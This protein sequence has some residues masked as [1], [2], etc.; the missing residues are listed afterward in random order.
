MLIDE[1]KKFRETI[2]Q[3]KEIKDS[4]AKV[5]TIMSLGVN[6]SIIKSDIDELLTIMM[7]EESMWVRNTIYAVLI[8]KFGKENII[9]IIELKIK[10]LEN[11]IHQAR[12]VQL[13]VLYDVFSNDLIQPLIDG[14]NKTKNKNELFDFSEALIKLEGNKSEGVKIIQ[15]LNITGELDFFQKMRY[16]TL[17]SNFKINESVEVMNQMIELEKEIESLKKQLAEKERKDQPLNLQ[18]KM[19]KSLLETQSGNKNDK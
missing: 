14:L 8:Q 11:N 6:E 5:V 18:E 15:R 17:I 9:T 16:K 2:A 7:K 19:M 3:L 12:L 4:F 13:L 10:E 1:R